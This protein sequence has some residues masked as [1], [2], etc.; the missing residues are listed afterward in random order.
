[1]SMFL[2]P[3]LFSLSRKV[4]CLTRI[5][6]NHNWTH[7]HRMILNISNKN[8]FTPTVP[9]FLCSSDTGHL[10]VFGFLKHFPFLGLLSFFF[11]LTGTVYLISF[12]SEFG[13]N[14]VSLKSSYL[15]SP[16]QSQ[17]VISIPVTLSCYSNYKFL[18]LCCPFICFFLLVPEYRI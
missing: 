1:M 5:F 11:H 7:Q 4:I 16:P 3:I 10:F 17:L 6:V 2:N 8:N 13:L 9:L 18:K 15:F 14:I 12:C